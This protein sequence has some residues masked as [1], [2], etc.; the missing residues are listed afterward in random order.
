[1]ETP[2]P[3]CGLLLPDRGTPATPLKASQACWELY[4]E[5]AV[6]TM[7]R[8]KD[9]IHQYAVDAYQAQ[10]VAP[11]A[12][13]I[14]PAFSLIGL[15]LALERGATGLQVQRAHMHLGKARR[16]W[17]RIELPQAAASLTVRDVL[18][19]APGDKRDA[20]LLEWC[21]AVWASWSHAQAWTRQIC[22][23]FLAESFS[24]RVRSR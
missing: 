17:P 10:H 18:D 23:E 20:K 9:F 13:N 14:G 4:G 1:M 11:S 24:R 3:G 22:D 6:Y 8:G 21:G 12:T 16:I 19:A 15:C 5:L 7:A 2:C